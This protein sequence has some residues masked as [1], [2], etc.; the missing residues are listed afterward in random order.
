MINASADAT[1]SSSI[2]RSTSMSSFRLAFNASS[3][4]AR[5]PAVVAAGHVSVCVMYFSLQVFLN[6]CC[7]ILE[8][9]FCCTTSLIRI[10]D[11]RQFSLRV[12]VRSPATDFICRAKPTAVMRSSFEVFQS[13]HVPVSAVLDERRQY[14]LPKVP[15]TSTT[16]D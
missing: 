6:L 10:A 7:N 1:S 15:A 16:S 8:S 13:R 11:I 2:V 5:L 12:A 14:F 3:M 9:P 4:Q